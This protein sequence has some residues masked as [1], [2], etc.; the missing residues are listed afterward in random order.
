MIAWR[1]RLRKI[2]RFCTEVPRSSPR[3]CTLACLVT[4][5][6][7]VVIFTLC[8]PLDS[9]TITVAL[10]ILHT[11]RSVMIGWIRLV[12]VVFKCYPTSSISTYIKCRS[13]FKAI[14]TPLCRLQSTTIGVNISLLVAPCRPEPIFST[15][16]NISIYSV[17]YG[18]Q[19]QNCYYSLD[20]S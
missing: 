2:R 7:L 12:T 18:N 5:L 10:V 19:I 4:P 9:T 1:L 8:R 14:G 16:N 11:L 17:I 3:I 6:N 13:Y 20:H 15:L